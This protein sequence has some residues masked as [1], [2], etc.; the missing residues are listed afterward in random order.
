M[1]FKNL[2]MI[3]KEKFSVRHWK[4]KELA[5]SLRTQ[6]LSYREIIKEVPVA[7]STISLWCR[8]VSLSASQ[9]ARLHN[10]PN[11]GIKGLQAIQTIFWHKRCEAFQKG[12]VIAQELT[13]DTLFIAGLM[14][15][16]AEGSKSN[17]PGLA[18][19]DPNVI[20]FMTE[21]FEKF[22]QI[23]KERMVIQLHLH[24]EQNE[25][26]MKSFWATL[27]G[28]PITNF[29]KSFIKSEGSGYKKNILYNG[30]AKLRIRGPGSTYL[31]FTI[32]GGIAGFLHKTAGIEPNPEAWMHKL[33][34]AAKIMGR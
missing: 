11:K 16:W 31:L 20:K 29:H 3:Q 7:K 8:H 9:K 18:N 17:G 24:S 2:N 14:L 34:Y 21:W 28:I 15:Y 26:L 10:Q 6:G 30:T 19:S 25:T 23:S 33:P 1:F 22:F 12:T 13:G 32:L 27:T 4:M 5:I